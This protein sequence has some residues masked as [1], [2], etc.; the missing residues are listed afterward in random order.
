MEME[1]IQ[2]QKNEEKIDGLRETTM[3]EIEGYFTKR[4][5]S[6]WLDSVETFF[7]KIPEEANKRYLLLKEKLKTYQDKYPNSKMSYFV[8]SD[9]PQKQRRKQRTDPILF[10]KLEHNSE[11]K[12]IEISRW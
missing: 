3:E 8:A 9:A 1:L 6:F 4:K 11:V 2:T 10:L 12:Y 5:L 7:E